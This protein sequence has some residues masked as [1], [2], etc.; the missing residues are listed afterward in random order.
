MTSP[1]KPNATKKTAATESSLLSKQVENT[2]TAGQ[3][4][5]DVPQVTIAAETG[6]PTTPAEQVAATAVAAVAVAVPATLLEQVLAKY[7]VSV[8]PAALRAL[9]NDLDTYVATMASG[10]P[11]TAEGIADGYQLLQRIYRQATGQTDPSLSM[12]CIDL[13]AV[14]FG[15]RS[16]D[17][18]SPRLVGRNPGNQQRNGHLSMMVASLTRFFTVAAKAASRRQISQEV[19]IASLCRYLPT[20]IVRVNITNYVTS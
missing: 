20:D 5:S 9:E 11:V 18:F 17:V 10:V 3:V 1:T 16:V 7:K 4:T 2:V 15:A 13:T 19:D 8:A 6:T 14:Y 12:M